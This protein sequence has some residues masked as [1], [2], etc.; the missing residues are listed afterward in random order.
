MEKLQTTRLRN[1]EFERAIY[2]ATPEHGTKFE[3]MLVPKYWANVA[4]KFKPGDRVEITAENGEWFAELMVAAAARLWAKM[5][6][7]RYVEL[8]DAA[9]PAHGPEA[10][11]EEADP[12]NDYDIKWAGNT[13]KWRIVRKADKEPLHQGFQTKEQAQ[14]WLADYLKA[15]A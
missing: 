10:T 13:A 1:A 2:T 8:V 5:A 12:A 7:L 3:D 11:P 4:H 9:A 6:V 14:S 15:V